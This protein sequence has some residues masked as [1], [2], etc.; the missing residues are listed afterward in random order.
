MVVT[1]IFY[2]KNS[3]QDKHYMNVFPL[4]YCP[5]LLYA[6]KN[7][8]K[9]FLL[10]AVIRPFL[11][12][13][14]P[15]YSAPG[16]PQLFLE[17]FMTTFMLMCVS[18]NFMSN[19]S[20]AISNTIQ[21]PLKKPFFIFIAIL[22][23]STLMYSPL[24]FFQLA[25]ILYN[26]TLNNFL[27]VYL[28]WRE[29]KTWRDIQF[30]VKGIM[31]VSSIAI[32]YGFFERFNDFNNPLMLY[33][34]TLNHKMDFELGEG[35]VGVRGGRVS[36]IFYSS[37]GCGAYMAAV[38]AFFYY[39]NMRHKNLWNSP[40]LVKI[41]FMGGLFFILLFS[42]GRG[43]MLYFAISLVF[44]LKLKSILRL[45]LFLPFFIIIFYGWL[46]PYMFTIKSIADTDSV[47][48]GGSTYAMR[49]VQFLTAFEIA[50][51]SP[52]LGYGAGAEA[53]W[54][55]QYPVLLGCESLWIKLLL[56]QGI[57]GIFS[58][59]YLLYSLV[60]LGFGESKRYVIGAVLAFIA[61]RTTTVSYGFDQYE[62]FQMSLILIAYRLELL[63]GNL[64]M[65]GY[66]N[67]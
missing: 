30:F 22:Y 2:Q 34:S 54:P 49:A 7:Y 33:E 31:I 66:F 3:T 17:T 64:R 28:L 23:L 16:L 46:E 52:W 36:S 41:I 48:T 47:D 26:Q 67:E 61:L 6:F 45:S 10:Y 35:I 5:I 9:A 59:I 40:K 53:Y 55:S 21:F 12:I 65:G 4:I 15:I 39:I 50:K 18:F 51:D 19:E 38:F 57:I 56:S 60:K 27:F 1:E 37:L 14:I 24:P 62:S 20:K 63:S 32:A 43:A 44:M 13:N 29:L 58:Y 42:N 25:S 11:N 8:H